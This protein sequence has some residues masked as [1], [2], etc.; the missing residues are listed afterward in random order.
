[1]GMKLPPS[2][3]NPSVWWCGE[4][5]GLTWNSGAGWGMGSLKPTLSKRSYRL[6]RE[7]NLLKRHHVTKVI[8]GFVSLC[9][10][11]NRNINQDA[12]CRGLEPGASGERG[13]RW[14]GSSRQGCREAG[15]A[16]IGSQAWWGGSLVPGRALETTLWLLR[17]PR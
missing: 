16:R 13:G 3:W 14:A 9:C 7:G 4:C 12:V 15:W 17:F 1:M 8:E 10:L 5:R 2:S 6:V 11:G